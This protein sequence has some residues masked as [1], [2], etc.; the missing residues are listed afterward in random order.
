MT[1]ENASPGAG[2]QGSRSG[3]HVNPCRAR[4]DTGLDAGIRAK[5]LHRDT[6]RCVRC[7]IPVSGEDYTIHSRGGR[8]EV[9]GPFLPGLIL[10]CGGF[11]TGCHGWV[12]EHPTDALVYGWL[13]RT[14]DDP[15]LVPVAYLAGKEMAEYYLTE[16]GERVTEPPPQE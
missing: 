5:V 16:D 4:W 10:L 1:T 14:G 3:N 7:G 12:H 9:T 15:L 6:G 8:A 13:V 11:A 2:N